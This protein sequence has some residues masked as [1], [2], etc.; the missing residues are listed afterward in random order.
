MEVSGFMIQIITLAASSLGLGN[1]ICGLA[2]LVF[3]TAKGEEFKA[4][5]IPEGYEFGVA[6]LVGYPTEKEGEPHKADVTKI[7][8]IGQERHNLTIIYQMNIE[9]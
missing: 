6:V 3:D 7:Q 8:Y 4:K 1:V 5:I 2:R 9:K